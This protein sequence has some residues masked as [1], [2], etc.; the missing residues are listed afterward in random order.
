MKSVRRT[1]SRTAID[2]VFRKF[3]RINQGEMALEDDAVKTG[4]HGDDQVGKLC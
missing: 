3:A 4:K 1:H 2:E